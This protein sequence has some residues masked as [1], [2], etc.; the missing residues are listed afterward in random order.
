MPYSVD[1]SKSGV[2]SLIFRSDKN[3]RIHSAYDPVTEAERAVSA[4]NP[5]KKKI[6]VV[7]GLGLGYQAAELHKKFP[8]RRIVAI[9]ESAECIQLARKEA[10]R[11]LEGILIVRLIT[12][13][14][15]LFE[16][17]DISSFTG[18]A[19]FT[20][21]PSY[22]LNPAFYDEI[23][24]EISRYVS[25]KISDLLTRF[26]F[27]EL[28]AANIIENL[29]NL[30]DSLTVGSLFNSF[31]GYPGIIVSA[32]PS[33]KKNASLLA[34]LTDRCLVCAVDTSFRVLTKLGISPHVVMALDAQKHSIRH[35]LGITDTSPL[36]LA[37]MV[38]FPRITQSYPGKKIM[39]TTAKYFN[40]STG[41]RMREGTPLM[42][43]V[44]RYIP[45]MGDI[46]SGGSVA[47]S[48]FDF[49]LS[50][51]CDPIILVGQ[52]LAYT[53]REIHTSGTYHND[54]WLTHTTRVYNLD[55][56]N[57]KVIRK[58]KISYVPAWGGK[59][60]VISDFVL[61]L[62]RQWF[63]DS[64]RKVS[65]KVINATEGG[66]R[67]DGTEEITLETLSKSLKRSNESPASI[68]EQI[69]NKTHLPVISSLRKA[70]IQ[71]ADLLS[72]ITGID[73]MDPSSE[74]KA[75]S[76][77]GNPILTPL[78]SPYLKKTNAYLNRHTDLPE[79]RANS[80]IAKDILKAAN[81]LTPRLK[82]AANM[83]D[84]KY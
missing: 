54:E 16:E 29:P 14:E 10:S 61:N 52:D 51:G 66:A 76:L 78:F 39:S 84:E 82:K 5:G 12:D 68:I 77:F 55:T 17:M 36:L 34:D 32:G 64:A 30:A 75:L 62:Y 53:G 40:D 8:D 73:P 81:D 56:I 48:L 46:Q 43:W 79:E 38:S 24:S 74:K 20:H 44:E 47:T 35:F 50:A 31:K 22:S 57:Q 67:I 18:F 58:R 13:L 83:L 27:E 80:L 37:D 6:I 65:V 9:E 71:S 72:P 26:E 4:F 42:E 19:V 21:R 45:P 69:T 15:N 33:L 1:R 3:V 49:L 25:S 59:G 41:K 23:I 63:E 60:E 2:P 70:L 28:W 7:L 11:N